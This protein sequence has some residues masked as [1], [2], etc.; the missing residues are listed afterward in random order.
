[1]AIP[2]LFVLRFSHQRP[3]PSEVPVK[4]ESRL[5]RLALGS[6]QILGRHLWDCLRREQRELGWNRRLRVLVG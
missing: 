4:D 2:L 5:K 1:M 3:E 6:E